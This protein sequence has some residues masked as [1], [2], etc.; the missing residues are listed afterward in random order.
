M[1]PHTGT[2]MIISFRVYG[3]GLI[4]NFSYKYSQN[5]KELKLMDPEKHIPKF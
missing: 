3:S 1:V 5:L 4:L 2:Q